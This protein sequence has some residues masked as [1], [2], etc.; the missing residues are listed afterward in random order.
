MS[1][2]P[3]AT[4]GV[5]RAKLQ[6]R[7]GFGATGARAG[8]N[9]TLIDEFLSDAQKELYWAHDW[10][11]LRRYETVSLGSGQTLIDYPDDCN[12]ERIKAISVLRGDVWSPPLPRGIS[13]TM[14]TTQTSMPS[15]PQRWEP[16]EQIEIFPEAD[17]AYSLRIFYIKNLSAF[18]ANDDTS[19]IDGDLIFTLAAAAAKA[20]YRQPDA[21][22]YLQKA[23]A[24]R[25]QLK[26][27]SWAKTKF[28]PNDGY[29]EEPLIMPVVV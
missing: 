4:L 21:P 12:P 20:H 27:K 15:W 18:V 16:Y 17:Q 25:L 28:N 3:Y 8:V 5:Q 9:T 13:P 24:L 11:R 7:L 1:V 23:E 10:V 19:D 6:R 26:A 29:M 22:L 14:Y 2:T